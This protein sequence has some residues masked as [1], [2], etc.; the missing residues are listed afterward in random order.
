MSTQVAIKPVGWRITHAAP[1]AHR[2]QRRETA[3]AAA[4]VVAFINIAT[5]AGIILL[6]LSA[7]PLLHR[8]PKKKDA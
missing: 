3:A 8:F 7:L 6:L 1:R 5:A 4:E 2:P